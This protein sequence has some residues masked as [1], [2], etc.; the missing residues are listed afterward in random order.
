I[1]PITM[2][3]AVIAAINI[4]VLTQLNMSATPC[5]NAGSY[6]RRVIAAADCKRNVRYGRVR[7]IQSS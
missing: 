1:P 6:L 4:A 7:K 2:K 5:P 3:R